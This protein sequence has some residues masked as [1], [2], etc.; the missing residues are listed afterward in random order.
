MMDAIRMDAVAWH[1][2]ALP[3]CIM[4]LFSNSLRRVAAE[5]SWGCPDSSALPVST[6][7]VAT[8]HPSTL[9]RVC[10]ENMGYGRRLL[11]VQIAKCTCVIK[12]CADPDAHDSQAYLAVVVL[13]LTLQPLGSWMAAYLPVGL[14]QLLGLR[15]WR[16]L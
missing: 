8:G 16:R 11:I 10:G 9:H 12:L 5:P 14:R 7:E 15:R 1:S 6:L 4:R 3:F 13:V 2:T